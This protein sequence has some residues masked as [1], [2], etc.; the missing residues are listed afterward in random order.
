MK[1]QFLSG[2]MILPY[3]WST[4]V[5]H[6]WKPSSGAGVGAVGAVGAVG[7]VGTVGKVKKFR[8]SPA[9]TTAAPPR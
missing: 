1:V 3:T 5:G 2:P 8:G 6:G 4:T 9:R 7:T